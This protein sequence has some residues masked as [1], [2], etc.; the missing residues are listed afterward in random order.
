MPTPENISELISIAEQQL[1]TARSLEDH[2]NNSSFKLYI[3]SESSSGTPF[4]N[5]IEALLV[6]QQQFLEEVV[7]VE[8]EIL[9]VHCENLRHWQ[10]TGSYPI[11]R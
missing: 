8:V 2:L 11:R 10:R 1:A 6:W 5:T 9:V 4:E 7:E 3:L